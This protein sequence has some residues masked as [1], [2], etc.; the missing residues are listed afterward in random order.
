MYY[1][2]DSKAVVLFSHSNECPSVPFFARAFEE[3]RKA[4]KKDDVVFLMM[5]ADPDADRA[6]VAKAIKT[7]DGKTPVQQ[8]NAQAGTLVFFRGRNSIH[9]VAPNEGTRTRMLAVL[10]YNAEEG[11]SLSKDARMTFYGRTG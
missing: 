8:L 7:Y 4:H 5:N 6:S 1:Q 10:A 2:E 9:R 3:V 11:T